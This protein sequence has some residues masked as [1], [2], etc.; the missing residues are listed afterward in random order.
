MAAMR[1]LFDVIHNLEGFELVAFWLGMFI[2]FLGAGFFVD[3]LM[4]KQGFGVFWNAVFAFTGAFF[5]LYVRYN[6]LQRQP[7]FF[8]EPWVTIG[9]LFMS[10]A[11]FLTMMSFLRNR[12]G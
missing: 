2:S 7:F 6:Y 11:I 8:F 5:G 4:Q 12:F 10:I 1:P 9:V 3:Y